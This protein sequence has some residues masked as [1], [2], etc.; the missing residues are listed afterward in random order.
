M[1]QTVEQLELIAVRIKG[2]NDCWT[3]VDDQNK[4]VYKS[5][6]D[7]LEAYFT[8][9]NFKG[10]YRLEPLNS[11]LYAIKVGEETVKPPPPKKYNLYGDLE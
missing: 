6:T 10:N 7:T 11:K 3:L 8:E 1:K 4:V 9:T 2:K 5:L